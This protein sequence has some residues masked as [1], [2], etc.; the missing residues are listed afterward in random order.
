MANFMGPIRNKAEAWLQREIYPSQEYQTLTNR[1]QQ[2]ELN[3]VRMLLS[4]AATELGLMEALRFE[5]T[6]KEQL[7]R[8]L[9]PFKTTIFYVP[10][11]KILQMWDINT[12]PTEFLQLIEI[13][14]RKLLE[15]EIRRDPQKAEWLRESMEIDDLTLPLIINKYSRY[16]GITR[17]ILTDDN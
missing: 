10:T 7:E 11:R 6:M 17:V 2:Y 5:P 16:E 8:I 14:K 4:R 9:E 13:E 1:L 12:R 15:E 3:N